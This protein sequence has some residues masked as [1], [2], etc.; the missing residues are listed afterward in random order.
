[1][2]M[3][4]GGS[5]IVPNSVTSFKDDP[6]LTSSSAKLSCLSFS[7]LRSVLFQWLFNKADFLCQYLS[8]RILQSSSRKCW[9]TISNFTFPSISLSFS[10]WN[11]SSVRHLY[12]INTLC[13]IKPCCHKHFQRA[14]TLKM[15][16]HA[17]TTL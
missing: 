16:K 15:Q 11:R 6:S 12:D 1:M 13:Y 14:F 9:T 4:R 7:T 2:T 3:W 17:V 10:Y 8:S 5:K